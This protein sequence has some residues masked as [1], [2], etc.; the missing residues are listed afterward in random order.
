MIKLA[1]EYWKALESFED[2]ILTKYHY[3]IL[4]NDST[5]EDFIEW[6]WDNEWIRQFLLDIQNKSGDGGFR[7]LWWYIQYSV[8]YDTVTYNTYNTIA[9]F[10]NDECDVTDWWDYEFWE[11]ELYEKEI[12]D[13]IEF[14]VESHFD[15]LL[16]N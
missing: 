1:A 9:Q 3:H 8:E 4:D 13:I 15:W 10:E 16:D 14:I 2:M 7:V 5:D 12:Y 6:A 11:D